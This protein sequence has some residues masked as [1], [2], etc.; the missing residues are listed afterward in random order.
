[1]RVTEGK[2]E[3]VDIHCKCYLRKSNWMW[4]FGLGIARGPVGT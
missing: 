2:V 1:M 4:R 3:G